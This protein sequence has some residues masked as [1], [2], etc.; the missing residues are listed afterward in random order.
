MAENKFQSDNI[1]VQKCLDIIR[2]HEYKKITY[3][4]LHGHT[5]LSVWRDDTN[6]MFDIN[7]FAMLYPKRYLLG[8][9]GVNYHSVDHG[10]ADLKKLFEVCKERE[11]EEWRAAQ[12]NKPLQEPVGA[13]PKVTAVEVKNNVCEIDDPIINECSN[14]LHNHEYDEISVFSLNGHTMFRVWRGHNPKKQVEIF[15]ISKFAMVSPA[16]YLLDKGGKNYHDEDY[17]F[18]NLGELFKLCEIAYA[19]YQQQDT[20]KKS[21]SGLERAKLFLRGLGAKKRLK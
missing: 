9:D 2:N 16:S 7:E 8:K 12:K 6:H 5:M 14:I 3:F 13:E 15:N 1:I 19:E 17:G 11:N 20:V 10:F 21:L 4:S 18:A